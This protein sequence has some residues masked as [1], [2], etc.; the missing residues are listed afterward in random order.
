LMRGLRNASLA[1]S[2]VVTVGLM[3]ALIGL[4]QNIWNPQ[5]ERDLPKF[6]YPSKFRLGG[7]FVSWHEATTILTAAALAIFLWF[8]L[9]RTR[10]GVAM[11]AVVDDRNLVG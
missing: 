3:V 7:V 2:L 4:A 9:N 5:D 6:F 11:R 10:T 8:L 1:T